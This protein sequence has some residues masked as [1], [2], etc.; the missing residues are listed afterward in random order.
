MKKDDNFVFET[1]VSVDAYMTKMEA[2]AC[3]SRFGAKSLNRQK[4]AFKRRHVTVDEFLKLAT[5]GYCFCNLFTYDPNRKY[6]IQAKDG[7]YSKV[8]PEYRVGSN[9][10]GM[11]LSFKADEFFHGTQTVF[12]DIDYTNYSEVS[13]Y[14]NDLTYQPTGVYMSFSDKQAKHGVVS[15]RFRLVYIFDKILDKAELEYVAHIIN[16]QLE[17]DTKEPLDDDCGKR[18]SQYMNGVYGN[19]EVYSS[20]LIYSVNDFQYSMPLASLSASAPPQSTP[21]LPTQTKVSF[22]QRMLSDMQNLGYDDFMHIYSTKYVYRYRVEKQEW[23][24]WILYQPTDDDYLQLWW[25]REKQM[26]GQHRRRK[27]FKNACLRRLMFPDMDADTML[28]NLYIDAHRFFDNSDGVITITTLRR[29]VEKS[30]QM[31]DKDLQ[32]YCSYEIQ[33]WKANRPKFIVNPKAPVKRALLAN[34]DKTIRWNELDKVYDPSKSVEE[35]MAHLDVSRATVYRYCKERNIPT[36]PNKAPTTAMKRQ[37]KKQHKEQ[38]IEQFVMY[39]DPNATIRDNQSRMASVGLTLS[40]GTISN[41]ANKYC[42]VS[43]DASCVPQYDY[44][45][46]S[47]ICTYSNTSDIPDIDMPGPSSFDFGTVQFPDW[48]TGM[49]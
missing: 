8:Y 21:V 14:L 5:N 3:L 34:I 48:W 37:E 36:T 33:Y 26:D 40:N 9:K 7:R 23:Q 19:P 30:F 35:N 20:Y 18:M 44:P 1:N 11:K 13:D 42:S 27:L 17:I 46:S 38:Q 31:T 2:T 47:D 41:W 28:F 39:Y 4:M 15:R 29:K 25:Y 32:N 22:D 16:A 10:G 12:V 24:D 43:T 6:W 49:Q 45:P